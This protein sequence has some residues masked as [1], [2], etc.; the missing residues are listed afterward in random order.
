MLIHEA[1][2]RTLDEY[3]ISGR[4]LAKAADVSDSAISLFRRGKKGVTDETLNKL[5]AAME[6]LSPG[7]R[8]YFCSLLADSSG[9]HKKLLIASVEDLPEEDLP[10]LLMAIARRWNGSVEL[11]G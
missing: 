5:M 7:S 8:R 9:D 10:R 3:N 1:F 11:I 6:T 4:T 2:D